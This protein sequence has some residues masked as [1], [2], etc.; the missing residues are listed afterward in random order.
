MCCRTR[1]RKAASAAGRRRTGLMFSASRRVTPSR[2]KRTSLRRTVRGRADG[3]SAACFPAS[4]RCCSPS[5]ACSCVAV[6]AAIVYLLGLAAA[7]EMSLGL[8]G[9]SYPLLYRHVP[10]STASARRPGSASSWS[11]SLRCWP[12]MGHAARRAAPLSDGNSRW[13]RARAAVGVL[14]SAGLLLEVLG[15]APAAGPLSERPPPLYA[16]LATSRL[17]SWPRFPIPPRDSLPGD[18]PRYAYMSTFHWMPS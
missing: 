17:A 3:P 10:S 1:S 11:S 2:P 4:C 12:R 14:I 6:P 7:F 16:W 5:S 13:R 8:Y 9:Y 18:E 15:G